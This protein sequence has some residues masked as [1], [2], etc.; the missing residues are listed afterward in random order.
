MKFKITIIDNDDNKRYIN[1]DEID[2]QHAHK[3]ALYNHC[4]EYEEVLKVHG[5]D[6]KCYFD[7]DDG[8]YMEPN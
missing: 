1:I 5:T 7:F 6:G 4:E 2:A 3:I 8:F